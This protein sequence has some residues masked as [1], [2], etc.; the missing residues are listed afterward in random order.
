[1]NV[2]QVAAKQQLQHNSN[3]KQ[4]SPSLFASA[5]VAAYFIF[6]TASA[7]VP[8]NSVLAPTRV[9]AVTRIYYENEESEW[10]SPPP[11]PAPVKQQEEE[12]E[13]AAKPA[14]K[15]PRGVT[16]KTTVVQARADLEEFLAQDD[17]L[18]VIKFH[19]AWYVLSLLE[20]RGADSIKVLVCVRL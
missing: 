8:Q 13:A 19:A 20:W 14:V 12:E 7:F 9:V 6:E 18:C 2:S 16:A 3:M 1:M 4:P 10:Y 17:R 5:L 15:L 11:P